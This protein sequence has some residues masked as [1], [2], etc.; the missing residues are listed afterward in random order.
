[1]M[2]IKNHW[3]SINSLDDVARVVREYYNYELADKIDELN[4]ILS[5]KIERLEYQIDDLEYQIDDL[6]YQISELEY[7]IEYSQEDD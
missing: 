3:E 6:E 2:Y 5:N 1:M 4:E 7:E